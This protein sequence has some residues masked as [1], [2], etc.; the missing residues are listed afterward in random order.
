MKDLFPK[1]VADRIRSA[2]IVAVVI[3]DEVA[4]AV[5]L[6]KALLE[7]GVSAMELTLRTPAALQSLEAIRGEC[8]DMFVGLGTVLA[9][10]QVSQA[11]QGK[12]AFG[13][14]PGFNPAVVRAAVAAG[15]PFAPGVATPSDIEGAMA[16]GCRLLK[17]FP[18]EPSGGISYLQTIGAPYAHLGLEYIP[19]GGLGK[20]N[21]T[22]YLALGNVAA[23]GGSWI[24]SREQIQK[25]DWKTITA[26]AR[27]ATDQITR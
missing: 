25:G 24:A 19:L 20:D 23:V 9:P 26:N 18:A 2:K 7:G 5:P 8:P 16:L 1:P 22:R 11:V 27:Q 17:F 12:A 10:E 13:V 4:H 15:L 3:V 14:A 6:A 21:F